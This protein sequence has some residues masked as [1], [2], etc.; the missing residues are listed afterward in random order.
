MTT[1]IPLAT[2]FSRILVC[3]RKIWL[4]CGMSITWWDCVGCKRDRAREQANSYVDAVRLRRRDQA[5]ISSGCTRPWFLPAEEVGLLSMAM[6]IWPRLRW[7]YL[8]VHVVYG[9][10][11]TSNRLPKC[12]RVCFGKELCS[13]A[14][15][16]MEIVRENG[17]REP[18]QKLTS[19]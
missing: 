16:W 18:P 11:W 7:R 14:G 2:T 15:W 19:G 17:F 13:L 5:A 8:V 9:E 4:H 6:T 10:I 1:F 3:E 12:S